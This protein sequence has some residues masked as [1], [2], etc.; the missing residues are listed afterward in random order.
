VPRLHVSKSTP[1]CR[2]LCARFYS[3][4]G[5]TID[6]ELTAHSRAAGSRNAPIE[7]LRSAVHVA[8][9]ATQ[10]RSSQMLKKLQTTSQQQAQPVARS[11]TAAAAAAKSRSLPQSQSQ[12]H[13]VNTYIKHQKS[14]KPVSELCP[15]HIL[16][17]LHQYRARGKK[18]QSAVYRYSN[19][20]AVHSFQC[21]SL[22]S[23]SLHVLC[24]MLSIKQVGFDSLL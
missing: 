4:H 23:S 5:F 17:L 21:I 2:A 24:A 16:Q 12:A 14:G 6:H 9:A 8:C 1:I 20:T 13:L 7:Q 15:Q 19:H 11:K 22:S 18:P 3:S 10:A